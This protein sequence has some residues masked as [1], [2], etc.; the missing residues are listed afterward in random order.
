MLFLST[1]IRLSYFNFFTNIMQ[2]FV[3]TLYIVMTPDDIILSIKTT[4]KLPFV[5]ESHTS[6]WHI[7]RENCSLYYNIYIW[8][9][10]LVKVLVYQYYFSVLAIGFSKFGYEY[11]HTVNWSGLSAVMR[12]IIAWRCQEVACWLANTDNYVNLGHSCMER[13]LKQSRKKQFACCHHNIASRF[14]R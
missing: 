2:L 6:K 4:F 9:W 8:S 3:V 7:S 11:P 10:R 5:C 12:I 1:C 13:I 14:N